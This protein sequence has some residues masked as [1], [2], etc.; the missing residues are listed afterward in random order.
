MAKRKSSQDKQRSTNHTNNP[1][2][3]VTRIPLK[4]GGELRYSGK[5]GSSCSTSGTRHVNL[6]TNPVISQQWGKNREVLTTIFRSLTVSWSTFK[7]DCYL[8]T[9]HIIIIW[10][11]IIPLTIVISY[12]SIWMPGE[13]YTPNVIRNWYGLFS[14][15]T[16]NLYYHITIVVLYV[17][18]QFDQN[19]SIDFEYVIYNDSKLCHRSFVH[20]KLGI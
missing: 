17:C 6:A 15:L 7:S 12:W 11:F 4:A 5:V 8:Q 13:E 9:N 19:P 16:T 1:K 18:P 10:Q 14:E 3:R 20:T 2:D